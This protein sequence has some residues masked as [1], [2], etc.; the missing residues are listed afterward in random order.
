MSGGKRL[1]YVYVSDDSGCIKLCLWEEAV[2][3]LFVGK[4]YLMKGLYIKQYLGKKHLQPIKGKS[5]FTEIEDV[6]EAVEDIEDTDYE[7]GQK[8]ECVGVLGVSYLEKSVYVLNVKEKLLKKKMMQSW[9]FAPGA[10]WCKSKRPV[11][12]LLLGNCWLEI[13]VEGSMFVDMGKC[14]IRLQMLGRT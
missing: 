7:E 11:K 3:T 1:Q 9:A 8:L 10:T 13:P 5:S 2:G 14:C 4:S 12:L 6:S